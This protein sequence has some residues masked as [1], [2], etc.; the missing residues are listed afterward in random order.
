MRIDQTMDSDR[1][2]RIAQM[3]LFLRS[4]AIA[5]LSVLLAGVPA[6][7]RADSELPVCSA[8]VPAAGRHGP[9][10]AE[11]PLGVN[12]CPAGQVFMSE[13]IPAGHPADPALLLVTGVC[14]PYPPDALTNERVRAA[15]ACPPNYVVTGAYDK[16]KGDG[17]EGDL[18]CTRINT[19][20]YELSPPHQAVYITERGGESGPWNS[21]LRQFGRDF[22]GSSLKWTSIPPALRYGLARVGTDRWN[23]EFCT[24]FPWGSALTGKTFGRGCSYTHSSLLRRTGGAAEAR[25]VTTYPDC[26]AVSQFLAPELSCIR[27]GGS[28][29][30]PP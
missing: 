26:L 8:W 19:D 22:V 1:Q 18:L 3:N 11:S 24:G 21:V 12:E 13:L 20:L 10:G 6:E 30:T 2:L 14:C 25:S 17:L 23:Y 29:D 15:V 9:V 7:T 27:Q 28:S 4:L 16:Q 5:S